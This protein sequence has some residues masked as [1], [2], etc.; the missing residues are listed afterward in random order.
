MPDVSAHERADPLACMYG[1]G[2]IYTEMKLLLFAP[3]SS[4][5]L[6]LCSVPPTWPCCRS[7]LT[8][9][10]AVAKAE[11][12]ERR[13]RAG[14]CIQ[15]KSPGGS[16]E[17]K[18]AGEDDMK[19]EKPRSIWRRREDPSYGWQGMPGGG[20]WAQPASLCGF[21]T[22]PNSRYEVK[23]RTHPGPFCHC[24]SHRWFE[25]MEEERETE[26]SWPLCVH[27]HK[28]LWPCGTCSSHLFP[29][30]FKKTSMW[31]S[32][33]SQSQKQHMLTRGRV[34]IS[35]TRELQILPLALFPRG[36]HC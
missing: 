31:V 18:G 20:P 22:M 30:G 13:A 14:T 9:L 35:M 17:P 26:S 2:E 1:W 15:S 24:L 34:P 8:W 28:S 23:T 27:A 10:R 12:L 6:F 4:P 3:L 16:G 11:T 7:W 32:F 21:R 19:E 33:L 5:L 29:G 25:T 36:C